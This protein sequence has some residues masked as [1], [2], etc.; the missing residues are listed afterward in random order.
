M[1]KFLIIFVLLFLNLE[2]SYADFKKIKKKATVTQPEVIFPIP[3]NLDKCIINMYVNKGNNPVTPVIKVDAPSGYG[4]D[5]RFN[6]ALNKFENF[7]RPCGGGNVE[8]CENVKR[9]ILL[10]TD[11]AVYQLMQWVCLKL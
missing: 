10:S 6:F 3:K 7:K 11:K 1:K 2:I 4:L 9:V 8:A 5:N